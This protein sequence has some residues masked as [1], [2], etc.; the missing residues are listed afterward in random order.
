MRYLTPLAALMLILTAAVATAQP[1]GSPNPPPSDEIVLRMVS[2][3]W[4]E[5]TDATVRVA[6]AAAFQASDSSDVRGRALAAL[7][8]MAPQANW[9]ITSF[10]QSEDSSG[11]ERWNILAEARI[12]ENALGGMRDRATKASEPGLKLTL[13]GIEFT[14]TLAEREAATAAVRREIYGRVTQEIAAL[15]ETFKDRSFTVSRVNFVPETSY[16]AQPR[17]ALMKESDGAMAVSAKL[18]V[19][20]EV[21][22]RARPLAVE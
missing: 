8:A 5:S 1:A 21:V 14:P 3:R 18:V 19:N 22:I 16:A 11:L 7:D 20:A 12:A 9:T 17:M 2:E 15:N 10:D 4:V 6:I 13:A